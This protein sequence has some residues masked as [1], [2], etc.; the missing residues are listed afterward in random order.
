MKVCHIV[1]G[2]V[3]GGSEQV[4][5][6]Y[7][8]KL[9]DDVQFELIYQFDP[10]PEIQSRFEKLGFKCHRVVAK[11]KNPLLHC[12]QIYRLLKENKYDAIHSHLDWYLNFYVSALALLAGIKKRIAHHHQAY[13]PKN[14]IVKITVFKLQVLNKIFATHYLACGN[15]AAKS[16]WGKPAVAKGKVTILPNAVDPKKFEFDEEKRKAIRSQLGISEDTICIGHV[17]RFYPQKNHAFLIQI[18]SEYHKNNPKSV[19]LLVGDGSLQLQV[20][21]QVDELGL[22]NAVIFSGLQKDS[23]PF[24]S[25]MDV[26]CFPSLWEGLP[27]V[28]IEVQYN[29]LPAIVSKEITSEAKISDGVKWIS[30]EESKLWQAELKKVTLRSSKTTIIDASEFDI[31]KK[32]QDLE[33]IYLEVLICHK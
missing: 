10:N 17:G 29:G 20:K 4:I 2:I 28:L 27:L 1:H 26:F 7:A 14:L 8:E 24:Y 19:L 15:A 13:H 12:L 3:G 33:K 18:F 31:N 5:L 23:A 32:Y 9:K 22:S 25:A 6:N 16:G 30:L 11:T 21:K